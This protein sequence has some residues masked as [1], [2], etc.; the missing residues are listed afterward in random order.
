MSVYLNDS[1]KFLSEGLASLLTQ[2]SRDFEVILVNDGPLTESLESV[3]ERY[4]LL[5]EQKEISFINLKLVANAGLGAALQF[6]LGHCKTDYIVRMDSDDISTTNRL[7]Q[8]DQIISEHPHVDV[9]GTYIEEFEFEPGDLNRVRVV[10]LTHEQIKKGSKLRN[11][12]NHVT[13]CMKRESLVNAGGY[14][15]VLWHEDYFLWFKMLSMGYSFLNY[16]VNTVYVRVGSSM[17]SRRSGLAYLKAELVFLQRCRELG[18]ITLLD[19]LIYLM[20]RIAVRSMPN[21]LISK[22]YSYLRRV[23]N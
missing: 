18:M 17:I 6:G 14:E 2:E 22:V 15:H 9:I 12:M 5:F 21:V 11:P 10:P 3:I 4:D 19:S 20:P 23:D 7:S 1:P 16:P 8:L 13:V